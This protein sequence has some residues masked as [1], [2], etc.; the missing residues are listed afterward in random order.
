MAPCTQPWPPAPKSRHSLTPLP[1]H[2]KMPRSQTPARPSFT[3]RAASMGVAADRLAKEPTG[4]SAKHQMPRTNISPSHCHTGDGVPE[5]ARRHPCWRKRRNH[6]S[7]RHTPE[8]PRTQSH[9]PFPTQATNPAIATTIAIV[10]APSPPSISRS[11]PNVPTPATANP[12]PSA[13]NP[14]ADHSPIAHPSPNK[15]RLP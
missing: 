5:G 15:E 6:L 9:F 10:T 8:R 4:N 11:T 14:T 12:H 7:N 3:S 13:Y 2:P 1:P